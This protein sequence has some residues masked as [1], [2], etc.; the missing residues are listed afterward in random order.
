MNARLSMSL[1]EIAETGNLKVLDA[2]LTA[3]LAPGNKSN[4]Q[5]FRQICR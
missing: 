2:V 3:G 4:W 5:I 1:A